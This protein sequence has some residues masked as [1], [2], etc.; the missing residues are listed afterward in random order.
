MPAG[1]G[2]GPIGQGPMTGRAAGFCAGSDRPGYAN[3]APRGGRFFRRGF[4]G[5]GTGA[6]R[7]FAWRR[8]AYVQQP[9]AVHPEQAPVQQ[10]QPAVQKPCQPA[11]EQ[12]LQMLEDEAKAVEDEQKYLK[13]ELESI[14]KRIEELKKE[15]R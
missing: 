10:V 1:D 13:Q 2:T 8:T 3:S 14:N 7:G 4:F 12:E 9:Q 15:N 11:T 5:K 6:G